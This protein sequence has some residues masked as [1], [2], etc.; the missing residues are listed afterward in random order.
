VTKQVTDLLRDV[1]RDPIAA[2]RDRYHDLARKLAR[3]VVA[4]QSLDA[5]DRAE[6]DDGPR[7]RLVAELEAALAAVP[8]DDLAALIG[9]DGA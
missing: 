8:A 4:R 1:H 6:H 7:L 3:I 9:D 2:E 5:Y